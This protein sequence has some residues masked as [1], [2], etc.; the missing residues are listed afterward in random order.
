MGDVAVTLKV[1]PDSP[2]IDLEKLREEISK[3]VKIQDYNT[4]EIAFGLKALR[5]LVVKPDTGGTED[6]EKQ[7]KEIEGVSDVEV[8]SV[9]LV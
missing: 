5:I 8:E 4:E 7:I 9:T 3:K 6:I 2:E 1:M